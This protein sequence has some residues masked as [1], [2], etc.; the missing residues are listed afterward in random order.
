[1]PAIHCLRI[2][3]IRIGSIQT[4]HTVRIVNLYSTYAKEKDIQVKSL[5]GEVCIEAVSDFWLRVAQ[6]GAVP[7]IDN[8]VSIYVSE[9][10]IAWMNQPLC[11]AAV[12]SDAWVIVNLRL[13]LIQAIRPPS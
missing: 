10:H 5:I 9:A 1:M 11:S 4:L 6:D 7:V 3:V 13:V 12:V 2:Q 8:S